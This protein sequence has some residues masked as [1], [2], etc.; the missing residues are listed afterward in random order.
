MSDSARVRQACGVVAIGRNEGE[1]LK[2]CL[3]SIVASAGQVVYVDS[4]STDDS[5]AFARS[6]GVAVVEIDMS[7]PFTAARARNA[8]FA[9]LRE[10]APEIEY[11]QFVDGDCEVVATWLQRAVEFLDAHAEVAVTC[12][13]R[14]ERYPEQSI[15]NA[16]CDIEWEAPAG[17]TRSCGGD[18]M[19]RVSRLEAAGGYRPDLIAGEE[20][21]LCVRLRAAGGKVWRLAEEMTLHDAAMTRFG[22]WWN[23]SKRAGYAF[24]NGSALHGRPPERHYQRE[25]RRALVWGLVFPTFAL[26]AALLVNP[27]ALA[28]FLAYP[29]QVLRVGLRP[30]EV[31]LKWW[32]AFFLILGRFPEGAGLFKFHMNRLRG[33]ASVLIE[34]K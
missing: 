26:V 27:W 5:V 23:R 14:R 19:M 18:A 34:Y 16:L 7:V 20:P 8:G 25:A 21:E 3:K 15:Y 29:L 28:L 24:A 31:P 1:R 32:R 10:I 9:R 6:L 17:E 33:R 11:V 4:G 2:Q 12:G 13:R 30:A 22:Q